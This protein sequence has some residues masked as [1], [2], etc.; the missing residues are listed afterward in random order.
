MLTMLITSASLVLRD[1]KLLTCCIGV[2]Y[3]TQKNSL[4]SCH[5]CH[6]I[7]LVPY[8]MCSRSYKVQES[9]K[10]SLFSYK[11]LYLTQLF[12]YFQ[13]P[14]FLLKVLLTFYI[15]KRQSFKHWS[16][17]SFSLFYLVGRCRK[18]CGVWVY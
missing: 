17:V 12:S 3:G 4:W 7:Q 14:P 11:C 5:F 8:F 15:R 18:G 9:N 2:G 16:F 13:A 6:V 10:I 1:Q